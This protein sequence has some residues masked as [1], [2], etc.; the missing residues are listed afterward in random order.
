MSGT[1]IKLLVQ[2]ACNDW[3]GQSSKN[4]HKIGG[5]LDLEEREIDSAVDRLESNGYLRKLIGK[6]M[7]QLQPLGIHKA[8]EA[9]SKEKVE[10]PDIGPT[11]IAAYSRGPMKYYVVKLSGLHFTIKADTDSTVS[12]SEWIEIS[13]E[14]AHKL[15]AEV[16]A[17]KRK[18]GLS[19]QN[20]L[21]VVYRNNDKIREM[22]P[23]KD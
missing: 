20:R 17:M 18:F 22:S 3:T 23:S 12:D 21:K 13:E 4:Y 10:T 16:N 1:A 2:I 9:L 5:S 6:G 11:L 14:E 8:L 15:A 7:C 19:D